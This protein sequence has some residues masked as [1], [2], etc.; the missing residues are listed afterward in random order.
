MR[1]RERLQL[2]NK[3][4]ESPDAWGLRPLWIV[5]SRLRP[6]AFIV[7]FETIS[8]SVSETVWTPDCW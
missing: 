7:L 5:D 4:T 8:V 2:F 1:K 6:T 3:E